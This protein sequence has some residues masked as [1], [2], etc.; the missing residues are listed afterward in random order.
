VLVVMVVVRAGLP[1]NYQES[2]KTNANARGC[3]SNILSNVI[4]Y[5]T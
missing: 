5:L 4:F 3:S 1:G 2:R